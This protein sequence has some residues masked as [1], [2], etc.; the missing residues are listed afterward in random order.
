MKQKIKNSLILGLPF[1]VVVILITLTLKRAPE[2]FQKD[3]RYISILEE[4]EE[5]EED[6]LLYREINGIKV[7]FKTISAIAIDQNNQIYLLAEKKLLIYSPTGDL[8]ISADI[9]DNSTSLTVAENGNIYIGFKEHIEVYSSLG[10]QISKWDSVKFKK[11]KNQAPRRKHR[12]NRRSTTIKRAIKTTGGDKKDEV[13]N[14]YEGGLNQN[15]YITSLTLCDKYLFVADAGNKIV[16]KYNLKGEVLG[17]LASGDSTKNIPQLIIPSPYFDVF[18]AKDNS[19]WVVNP[20]NHILENFTIDGKL[21][22]TWGEKSPDI[23]GFCGCCN[24][25]NIAMLSDGSFITSEKGYIRVKLYSPKGEFLGV[26]V[27]GEQFIEGT[28]GLDIAI[29]SKDRVFIIDTKKD[30]I[31]IFV[32]NEKK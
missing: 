28:K 13:V 4:V 27:G 32:K 26:V 3:D 7:P 15:S 29:D 19:I 17:S 18:T 25:T 30:K 12:E 2:Q 14:V 21:I 11:N 24:P 31:R 9:A 10:K 16:W 8:V 5:I 22:T 6:L 23:E 1:I 20:G